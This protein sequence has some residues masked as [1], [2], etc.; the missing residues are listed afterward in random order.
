[1]VAAINTTTLKVEQFETGYN[2]VIGQSGTGI[3]REFP[4]K[5]AGAKTIN[6]LVTGRRVQVLKPADMGNPNAPLYKD[7][8][9]KPVNLKRFPFE[10]TITQEELGELTING[11]RLD[12]KRLAAL[13][14]EHNS[15]H[16]DNR[17]ETRVQLAY[18][19]LKG[20]VSILGSTLVDYYEVFGKSRHAVTLA[21]YDPQED[22]VKKLHDLRHHLKDACKTS[23]MQYSGLK[24]RIDSESIMAILSHGSVLAQGGEEA[25]K[26]L[27]KFIDAPD[28]PIQVFGFTFIPDEFHTLDSNGAVYPNVQKGLF[29]MQRYTP[30]RMGK[31]R[32]TD[33]G[34]VL[35]LEPGEHDEF[36]KLLTVSFD[37]PVVHDPTV[38]AGLVVVKDNPEPPAE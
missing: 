37:L 10:T 33:D 27:V 15:Q 9:L 18:S 36:L 29:S 32:V 8:D 1:M 20:K 26:R 24:V 13:I 25:K 21:I 16:K 14:A 5:R 23:A 19:A 35:S 34:T 2:K 4:R 38:L 22:V 28:D 6:L 3:L 11:D 12:P 17:E 31:Q 7:E 30:P